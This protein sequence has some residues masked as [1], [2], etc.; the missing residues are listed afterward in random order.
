MDIFQE[1][2]IL[3]E[4]SCIS[5][6]RTFVVPDDVDKNCVKNMT[7]LHHV[8]CRVTVLF[9]LLQ[10][11]RPPD[12][13]VNAVGVWRAER[14][15]SSSIREIFWGGE[16]FLGSSLSGGVVPAPRAGAP[17]VLPGRGQGKMVSSTIR[18]NDST[19]P[20][21][22]FGGIGRGAGLGNTERGDPALGILSKVY[23]STF[24]HFDGRSLN[25][26]SWVGQPHVFDG[27]TSHSM[28]PDCQCRHT[29]TDLQ[30]D[31]PAQHMH[32]A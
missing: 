25:S 4:S 9:L 19:N 15:V 24:L 32:T 5:L 13:G 23:R 10:R 8:L 11:G 2:I 6:P 18:G 30:T 16:N 3:H 12:G 14:S 31:R 20:R 1:L 27:R 21:K 29:S 26:G 7:H 17:A 22:F 28:Y